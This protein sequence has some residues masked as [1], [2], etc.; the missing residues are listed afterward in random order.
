MREIFCNIFKLI[1]FFLGFFLRILFENIG[2]TSETG[3]NRPQTGRSTKTYGG[4]VQSEKGQKRFHDTRQK[5]EITSKSSTQ[6]RQT[7]DTTRDGV[8][9]VNFLRIFIPPTYITRYLTFV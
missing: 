1:F 7:N 8:R 5:E 4:G 9:Y 6:L 2:K 3:G